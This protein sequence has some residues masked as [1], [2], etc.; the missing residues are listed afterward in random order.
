[1]GRTDWICYD[2]WPG[3]AQD[4]TSVDLDDWFSVSSGKLSFRVSPYVIAMDP[5]K[6]KLLVEAHLEKARKAGMRNP[7]VTQF[8]EKDPQMYLYE[9][10]EGDLIPPRPPLELMLGNKVLDPKHFSTLGALF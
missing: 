5:D 3:P 10:T 8:L 6:I 1:V 7:V 2:P 4:I 9:I